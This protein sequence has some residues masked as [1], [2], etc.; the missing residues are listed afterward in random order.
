MPADSVPAQTADDATATVVG[1]DL[2]VK[3]LLVAAP[4][5]DDPAVE[6]ALVVDGGVE[7]ALYDSLG[8]TLT[9]FD[10]LAETTEAEAQAVQACRSM[11][12][13]RFDLG[14]ECLL[15][16][17][18]RVGA[19]VVA[20]EDTTH[21]CGSLAECARGRT[22][23]GS[24]LLPTVRDYLEDT[25]AAA[26]YQVDRVDAAYTTQRCHVCGELADVGNATISCETADCPVD[27]VCRDRSAAATIAGRI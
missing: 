13:Q 12:H 22:K 26:G 8:D 16:Y 19:D 7:R 25:L 14:A 18:D 2:G 20:L 5:T 6:D 15:E 17:L 9:R 4:A 1:V 10:Q 27:V 21:D 24:W 3:R 23:V 11:L